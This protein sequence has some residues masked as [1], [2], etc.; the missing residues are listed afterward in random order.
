M[1]STVNHAALVNLSSQ[2][3]ELSHRAQDVLQRYEDTIQHAQA[4]QILNGSAGNTNIN[5]GAEVKEAQMKI[6]TRFQQVNDLLRSGAGQYTNADED[7]SQQL[8][9]VQSHIRFH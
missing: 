5:T 2:M 3:D 4:A 1:K 8:A 7:N 6:Q 9:S